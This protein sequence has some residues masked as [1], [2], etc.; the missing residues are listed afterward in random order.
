MS[1]QIIII[2]F[3]KSLPTRKAAGKPCPSSAR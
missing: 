2:I 3:L 1:G